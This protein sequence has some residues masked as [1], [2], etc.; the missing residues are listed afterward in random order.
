MSSLFATEPPLR[1]SLNVLLPLLLPA[2]R[3]PRHQE[4]RQSIP[5]PDELSK[6]LLDAA[7][8]RAAHLGAATATVS[9]DGGKHTGVGV[10]SVLRLGP[11]GSVQRANSG[12]NDH[13]YD[14]GGGADLD[15]EDGE[16]GGL[17]ADS[18]GSV[19]STAEGVEGVEEDGEEEGESELGNVA[20]ELV[21]VLDPLSMAAQRASTLL[22]LVSEVE[23]C[24]LCQTKKSG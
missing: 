5:D 13:E 11:D 1:P 23:G 4:S 22:S 21:A 6:I 17:G 18:A 9:A 12:G 8:E 2:A 3:A 7:A 14:D 16:D 15:E 10:I 20:V 24:L 19:G